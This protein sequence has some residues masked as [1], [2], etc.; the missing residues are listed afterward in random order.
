M[1]AWIAQNNQ[2]LDTNGDGK[3]DAEEMAAALNKSAHEEAQEFGQNA[4]DYMDPVQTMMAQ[5]AAG[6]QNQ[7]AA[8]IFKFPAA[9]G[10][11]PFT[12]TRWPRNTQKPG[13]GCRSGGAD[14]RGGVTGKDPARGKQ[15]R[16]KRAG[17]N[18]RQRER[19][20]RPKGRRGL[21]FVMRPPPRPA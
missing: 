5:N 18:T 11:G 13:R 21:F 8:T 2:T 1:N 6:G 12:R 3:V 7:Q 14:R 20:R 9:D 15:V 17:E 19:L 4:L 16:I 10:N